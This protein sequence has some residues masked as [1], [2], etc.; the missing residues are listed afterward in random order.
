MNKDEARQESVEIAQRIIDGSL[1]PYLGALMIWKE[2]IN[3]LD[4]PLRPPED[5]FA[6]KSNASAIEDIKWNWEEDGGR[7]NLELEESCRK[8]ILDAAKKLVER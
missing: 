2:I 8:E 4:D 1:D 7:P 3:K 5:L 6:F